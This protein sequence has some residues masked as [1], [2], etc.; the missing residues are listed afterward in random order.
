MDRK[1]PRSRSA[2][3]LPENHQIDRRLCLFD[4]YRKIEVRFNEVFDVDVHKVSGLIFE[5]DGSLHGDAPASVHPHAKVYAKR[6]PVQD[7]PA[8]RAYQGEIVIEMQGRR[9]QYS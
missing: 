8:D 9:Q 6:S 4:E 5:N 1:D 7:E 3:A 2:A